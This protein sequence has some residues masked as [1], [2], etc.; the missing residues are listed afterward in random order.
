M[1]AAPVILLMVL[2]L[3]SC[4]SKQTFERQAAATASA[5]RTLEGLRAKNA[6]LQKRISR[7]EADLTRRTGRSKRCA[8]QLNAAN[9]DLQRYEKEQ[10]RLESVLGNTRQDA[11]Q[12]ADRCEKRIERLKAERTTLK[13]RADSDRIA[14]QARLAAVKNTC[15][16]LTGAL[17][18][19]RGEAT[20]RAD[21]LKQD[22]D[23]C[24]GVRLK[25][26]QQRDACR[27]KLAQSDADRED[28]KGRLA[29]LQAEVKV[30]EAAAT[31]RRAALKAV[32]TRLRQGLQQQI[33]RGE[34]SVSERGGRVS[35]SIDLNT[36]FAGNETDLKP[37]GVVLL[38]E[39]GKLLQGTK[40]L[41]ID[42]EGHGGRM[43]VSEELKKG[44]TSRWELST[45]RA[46]KVLHS[47]RRQIKIPD[48]RLA[49]V[50]FGPAP[51]LPEAG[52]ESTR[53]GK[54]HID[55]VILP[56]RQLTEQASAPRT[57]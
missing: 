52:S 19:E 23:Q 27:Q 8:A 3:C 9:E 13:N 56:K 26:E 32:A 17:E 1:R 24:N 15:D 53:E 35:V 7:L 42:I 39:I 54:G 21:G 10:Q 46:V 16:Q 40:G 12:A 48:R 47:L 20:A 29:G 25:L 43:P 14:G 55:I 36:L 57:P 41:E 33:D 51:L 11:S 31:R 49:I 22:L 38:G 34:L 6:E 4:V 18:Q 28:L 5:N 50:D 30:A 2:C 44:V 45:A 37:A